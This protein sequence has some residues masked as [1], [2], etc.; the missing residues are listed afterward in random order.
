MGKLMAAI[1][2]PRSWDLKDSALNAGEDNE[3]GIEAHWREIAARGQGGGPGRNGDDA[4]IRPYLIAFNPIKRTAFLGLFVIVPDAE[5]GRQFAAPFFVE[6]G[7]ASII[8][9]R[10]GLEFLRIQAEQKGI[11]LRILSSGAAL[12]GSVLLPAQGGGRDAFAPRA[13]GGKVI[14][15]VVDD[16]TAIFNER[17]RDSNGKT[18]VAALWVMSSNPKYQNPIGLGLGSVGRF[19]G[20][21][22]IDA[23][24]RFATQAGVFDE[25]AAYR[26]IAEECAL[27]GVEGGHGR[28]QWTPG[29][30]AAASHGTKVADLFA[31]HPIAGERSDDAMLVVQ[32][33]PRVIGEARG[34][35][36]VD[37]VGLAIDWIMFASLLMQ[38]AVAPDERAALVIVS[39]LGR[40]AGARVQESPFASYV[41]KRLGSYGAEARLV[42]PA[43]N[44]R[45]A[46][47]LVRL[48]PGDF[49]FVGDRWMRDVEMLVPPDNHGPVIVQAAPLQAD[50]VTKAAIAL[51]APGSTEACDALG[52]AHGHWRALRDERG[53]PSAIA[54]KCELK[55]ESRMPL[56][57]FGIAP[58]ARPLARPANL[59]EA[60]AGIWRINVSFVEKPQCDVE[61]RIERGEGPDD[62][63]GL[64]RQ[65][66]FVDAD[67]ERF[68][69]TGH[70]HQ[71][72]PLPRK[73]VIRREGTLNGMVH[74]S[75][76]PTAAQKAAIHLA[77]GYRLSDGAPAEYTGAGP[78]GSPNAG[79]RPGPDAAAP[80][81]ATA[82]WPLM[83]T[84]GNASGSAS[85]LNG[86]SAAA[87]QLGRFLVTALKAHAS[88]ANNPEGAVDLTELAALADAA[89][90]PQNRGGSDVPLFGS[91]RVPPARRLR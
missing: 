32:L 7:L 62:Y 11:G 57:V 14:H 20:A 12:A 59:P 8:A 61:L 49:K 41:L 87:P 90:F 19:Y 26:R 73:S 50:C 89:V 48:S 27:D 23:L 76:M 16:A 25:Q 64:Y 46:S 55:R 24:V 9:N 70:K 71:M 63:K 83:T 34:A 85:V 6:D 60:P 53:V 82:A 74:G 40:L 3:Q 88:V 18:R 4:A 80:S 1:A 44:A 54:Y 31:G 69:A 15:G 22:Q 21:A 17:F 72:D 58:T 78:D 43:G 45:Q 10:S 84:T 77:G 13:S 30:M 38:P 65:A 75:P 37:L 36:L 91:G 51:S 33:P 2:S 79:Y 29:L 47:C 56:V 39:S 35:G 66:R 52:I 28:L 81:G 86:T 5:S 68:D 67:Y 42:L